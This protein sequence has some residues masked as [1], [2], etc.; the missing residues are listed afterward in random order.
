MAML[1]PSERPALL[2]PTDEQPALNERHR[3]ARTVAAY[4][5]DTADCRTLL[6]MLGLQPQEGLGDPD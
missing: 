2:A 3:A 4:A 5:R 6:S 1:Y